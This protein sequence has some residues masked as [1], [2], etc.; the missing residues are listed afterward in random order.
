MEEIDLT[1]VNV[2]M[3]SYYIVKKIYDIHNDNKDSDDNP[4]EYKLITI[5]LKILDLIREINFIFLPN[6][7]IVYDIEEYRKIGNLL[8]LQVFLDPNQTEDKV[9]FHTEDRTKSYELK[10]NF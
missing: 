6:V 2:I 4:I 7:G 9:I 1:K 5:N 10:V 8:N 3:R